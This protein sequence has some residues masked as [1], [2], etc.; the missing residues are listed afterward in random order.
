MKY[1]LKLGEG[2]LILCCNNTDFRNKHFL[3]LFFSEGLSVSGYNNID[4]NLAGFDLPTRDTY[5]TILVEVFKNH[6]LAG[7]SYQVDRTQDHAF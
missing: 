2:N 4:K 5:F 6:I 1:I 7:E 3:T